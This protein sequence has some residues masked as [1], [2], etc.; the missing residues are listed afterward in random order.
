[1]P[2]LE[3]QQAFQ[4]AFGV[5]I[6]KGP[7]SSSVPQKPPVPRLS[8]AV[9]D[10]FGGIS[11]ATA[12]KLDQIQDTKDPLKRVGLQAK[13]SAKVALDIGKQAYD[14]GA[15]VVRA[16]PRLAAKLPLKFASSVKDALGG[17][18]ETDAGYTPSNAFAKFILG[19]DKI[20]DIKQDIQAAPNFG[21]DLLKQELE[22]LGVSPESALGKAQ[23]FG[24][25]VPLSVAGA[26]VTA[27]D[28]EPLG[29]GGAGKK[30]A[31]TAIKKAG[32]EAVQ[33]TAKPAVKAAVKELPE[34]VGTFVNKLGVAIHPDDAKIMEAY[35]DNV[36][37]KGPANPE[38]SLDA[39]RIA[40]GYG[41]RMPKTEAGLANEFDDVLSRMRT[42][43]KFDMAQMSYAKGGMSAA[44]SKAPSRAYGAVAGFTPETDEDG[45]VTGIGYDP[46][47]GLVGVAGM[48][49]AQSGPGKQLIGELTQKFG[50]LWGGSRPSVA[51]KMD[52]LVARYGK[53][54]VD[55]VGMDSLAAAAKN[56]DI[57][58]AEEMLASVVG[59]AYA[60][61]AAAREAASSLRFPDEAAEAAYQDFRRLAARNP[62]YLDMDAS[63]AVASL[64][65]SDPAAEARLFG[66]AAGGGGAGPTNDDVLEMYK[67]RFRREAEVLPLS[68]AALPKLPD[69]PMSKAIPDA[70]EGFDP[71][72]YVKE[73]VAKREAARMGAKDSIMSRAS[74]GLKQ[75]KADLVDSNAPIEDL[76][77][78]I[79]KEGKMSVLPKADISNQID[80]AYKAPTL[81]GQFLKDNGLED[82]IRN[83]DDLD[84]FEQ[85]LV[86]RQALDVASNGIET[87]RDLAKDKALVAAFG[88][89]FEAEAE[90][91]KEYSGKLLDYAVDSGL[92]GKET[93]AKLR[94]EYP[95]YV[96]INRIFAEGEDVSKAVPGSSAVASLSKQT[97]V[98]GLKGSAREIESPLASFASKT[99]DA[100]IQGERNKAAR[101]LAGYEQIGFPVREL[102]AGEKA[103]ERTTFSFLDN[104]VKRTFVTTPEIASAAHNWDQQQLGFIGKVLAVPVRVFKV[105]TTGLNPSFVVSNLFRDQL[106]AA[107]N[108]NKSL[109]A[110]IPKYVMD[111]FSGSL[112]AVKKGGLYDK[113][114]RAAATGKAA[115]LAR[116]Q[117]IK[118]VGAIRSNRSAL[119]KAAYMVRNPSELLRAAEDVVGVTEE[120][121]RLQQFKGTLDKLIK[122]GRTLEDA[123]ILAA[124]AARENTT[125]FSR[126]GNYGRVL[127]ATIPYINAAIQ[128]K[129]TFLRVLAQDPKRAAARIAVSAGVPVLSVT[130]W[131]LSSPERRAAYEDIPDWEKQ[132]H[133]IILPP[134]PTKDD[135]GNYTNVVKLPIPQE[136]SSVINPLRKLYEKTEGLDGPGFRDLAQSV[137]GIV[138]PIDV[139]TENPER[140]LSNITPQVLKPALEVYANK[141]FYTG[142]KIVRSKMEGIP[143]AEQY[144]QGTS[145]IAKAA[146]RTLGVSPM[147][148]DHLIKGYFGGLGRI[149][150]GRESVGESFQRRFVSAYGGA[151]EEGQWDS[152]NKAL[153]QENLDT[154]R[155]G[156]KAESEAARLSRLPKEEANRQFNEIGRSDPAM[157]KLILKKI[158]ESNAGIDAFDRTVKSLN[159]GNRAEFILSE[160]D[161]RFD[162][163]EEKNAYIQELIK[164]DIIT[165]GVMAEMR[166]IRQAQMAQ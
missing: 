22:R 70:P 10:K 126:R 79:Q 15:D 68:R 115:D 44:P 129:R 140:I 69:G 46:K 72:A 110:N 21:D 89:R 39:K 11:P 7:V 38:L 137:L 56:G 73:M 76:L 49:A 104:G 135:K 1:M 163:A 161:K 157:G 113:A 19:S 36:R 107:A 26:I 60:K 134:S 112:E 51:A 41:M 119:S 142:S 101:L 30:A 3:A 124:K 146:G 59:E 75:L 121:T 122:E 106:T 78:S 131:N 9:R 45:N 63:G 80:R 17:T 34:E 85:Y 86:A 144:D 114:V 92:V 166:K 118:T 84:G 50:K 99:A 145:E 162:T 37:L 160:V 150:S 117:A 91:V 82:V 64:S 62:A 23:R 65:K 58:G 95:N 139:D 5:R 164:K 143:A 88:P 149:V 52:E 57:N 138:S 29:V 8:D 103:A 125:N 33:S 158:R 97:V 93:A 83:V 12:A 156:Q 67:D 111:F 120:A 27:S 24:L 116:G 28:A 48:S 153:E 108:D 40:E 74:T 77:A 32:K 102:K 35:I 55:T 4:E 96:P 136:V 90:A 155:R 105:G 18:A 13:L 159:I 154:Y 130:A 87:G 2:T 43:A 147:K 132:A 133:I 109:A 127:S 25:A 81:A 165:E 6:P 94:A 128:G 152:L 53:E 71:E 100:F 148:V 61:K 16:T 151:Q 31:K 66:H 123:T 20:T 141:D 14:F 98:R 47:M 42:Q 54:A